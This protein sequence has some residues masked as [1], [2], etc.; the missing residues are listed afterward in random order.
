MC[1]LR[2]RWEQGRRVLN[3]VQGTRAQQGLCLPAGQIAGNAQHDDTQK[4]G[5]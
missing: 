4:T 2:D 3:Y 5:S 1:R